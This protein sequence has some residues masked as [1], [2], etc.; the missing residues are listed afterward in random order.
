MILVIFKCI[1]EGRSCIPSDSNV[2]PVK[3]YRKLIIIGTK[4]ISQSNKLQYIMNKL[5]SKPQYPLEVI[6]FTFQN[7]M[8][9]HL[10]TEVKLKLS[11]RSELYS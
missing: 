8:F 7:V 3:K 5:N 2:D 11:Y 6:Q 4:Y 10:G 1:I 9:I